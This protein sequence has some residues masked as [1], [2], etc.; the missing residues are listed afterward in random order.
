MLGKF[1]LSTPPSPAIT[2]KDRRPEQLAECEKLAKNKLHYP[3]NYKRVSEIIETED[4]GAQRTFEWTF[5]GQNKNGSRRKATAIC[6]ANN[7]MQIA[8]IEVKLVE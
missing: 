6:K 3:A 2:V 7:Y 5:S 1:A 4:N 8:T